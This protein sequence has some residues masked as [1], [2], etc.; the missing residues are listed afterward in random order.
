MG[1]VARVTVSNR[2]SGSV[3]D[4]TAVDFSLPVPKGSYEDILVVSFTGPKRTQA[5]PLYSATIAKDGS[6]PVDLG[7]H[8]AAKAD[9][10]QH[11]LQRS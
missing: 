6:R 11:D 5:G 3:P 1:R 4:F 8:R 9:A 2:S 7:G 10:G